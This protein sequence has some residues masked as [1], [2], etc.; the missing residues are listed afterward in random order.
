MVDDDD[1]IIIINQIDP[2]LYLVYG[3]RWRLYT[4]IAIRIL[5]IVNQTTHFLFL[6]T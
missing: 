6:L 5:Y 2:F 1:I 4:L 3:Y